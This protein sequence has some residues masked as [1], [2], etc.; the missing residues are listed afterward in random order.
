MATFEQDHNR[1]FGDLA[2]TLE[3]D[4]ARLSTEANGGRSILFVYPPLEEELYIAEARK[5][6]PDAEV[7]DLRQLFV[8]FVDSCGIDQLQEIY[9]EFGNEIYFSKNFAE[10]TFFA[11]VIDKISA[12]INALRTPILVHTGTFYGMGFSNI[13]IMDHEVVLKSKMPVVTFYPAI[14]EKGNVMFLGKQ[15]ASRYRCVVIS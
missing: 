10:S 8:E 14:V 3:M 11:R 5:R 12:A 9:Q 4:L 7:I 2:K 6:F 13:N 15:V 1:L